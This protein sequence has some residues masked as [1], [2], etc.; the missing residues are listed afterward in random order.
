MLRL[1]RYQRPP[2]GYFEN[3]LHEFRRRRDKSLPE[4]FWS[5]CVERVRDIRA[6]ACYSAGVV[7]AAACVAVIAIT[8][9][10]QPEIITHLAVQTPVPATLPIIARRF[11]FVPPAFNPTLDIRRAVLPGSGHIGVLRAHSLRSNEFIPLNLERDSL[12]DGSLPEK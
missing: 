2:P 7:T 5:S 8:I 1:K 12:D 10:Q 9:H 11:D 3:F 4:P 6:W